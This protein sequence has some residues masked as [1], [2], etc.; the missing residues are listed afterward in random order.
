[1][2]HRIVYRS[3]HLSRYCQ[4]NRRPSPSIAV[5]SLYTESIAVFFRL[6]DTRSAVFSWLWDACLFSRISSINSSFV[7]LAF[8]AQFTWYNKF[9]NRFDNR[10]L[11]GKFFFLIFSFVG[12]ALDYAG[13]PVSFWAHV[14]STVSYRIV[15]QWRRSRGVRS[16]RGGDKAVSLTLH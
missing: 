3:Q 8:N 4:R 7:D 13:H 2:R 9:F 1:M 14:N 16:G 11:L 6:A 15:K 5:L 12:R 10:L